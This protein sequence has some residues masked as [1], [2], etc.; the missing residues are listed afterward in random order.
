M[1]S[2]NDIRIAGAGDLP[3][4]VA[5]LNVAFAMERDFMDRDRIYPSEVE[6]YMKAGTYFVED[7]EGGCLDACMYLERRGDRMY[8]GMLAV[9]PARQGSG[10]GKRLMMF[11]EQQ[12]SAA[13]CTNVDI[14]VV[15][16]R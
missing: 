6:A 5:L 8:L 10:L 11:A 16:L 15:N 1:S 7:G 12:T 13:G 14:R 9:D 4:I 3:R 2:T